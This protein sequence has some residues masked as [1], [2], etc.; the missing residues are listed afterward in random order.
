MDDP[1]LSKQQKFIHYCVLY[2]YHQ[3]L[4]GKEVQKEGKNCYL[5]TMTVFYD[6]NMCVY[7]YSF[8]MEHQLTSFAVFFF[9]LLFA[10]EIHRVYI[11][12]SII[13]FIVF[14]CI[15]KIDYN[16]NAFIMCHGT[17]NI[18]LA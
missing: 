5:M 18:I 6:A 14:K 11:I 15:P 4:R 12:R 2:H 13:L 17:D 7:V 1:M 10:N 8:L 16:T 9:L 3:N